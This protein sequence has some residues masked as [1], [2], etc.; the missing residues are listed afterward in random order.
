M[1]PLNALFQHH[2]F[3]TQGLKAWVIGVIGAYDCWEYLSLGYLEQFF[4]QK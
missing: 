1:I 3:T 2:D 4:P